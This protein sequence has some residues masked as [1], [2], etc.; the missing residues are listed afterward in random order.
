M[1]P[2]HTL[3]QIALYGEKGIGSGASTPYREVTSLAWK[4]LALVSGFEPKRA[5]LETAVLPLDHTR[6]NGAT[7]RN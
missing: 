5:V 7:N 4:F 6:M 2:K 1:L 3:Y